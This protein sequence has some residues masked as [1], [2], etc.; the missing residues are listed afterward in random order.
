MSRKS[1]SMHLAIRKRTYCFAY[2]AHWKRLAPSLES[3]E[4]MKER[5]KREINADQNCWWYRTWNIPGCC[6]LKS[7]K[8]RRMR[9]WDAIFKCRWYQSVLRR[10][11]V[12]FF[13]V[14]FRSCLILKRGI[15]IECSRCWALNGGGG[16]GAIVL[17]FKI[18]GKMMKFFF[19]FQPKMIVWFI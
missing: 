18:A 10:K 11:N 12:C 19:L 14:F 2:T 8:C 9:T 7:S 3:R 17:D 16:N 5:N 4:R 13:F 1:P 15:L 6:R